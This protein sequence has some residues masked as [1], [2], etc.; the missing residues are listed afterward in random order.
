MDRIQNFLDRTADAPP[1]RDARHFRTWQRISVQVQREVRP[2]A[3]QT[4]FADEA[5]VEGDLDRAFT[6]VVYSSSKPCYGQR[7]M[8]FTYDIGDPAALTAALRLIG[9]SLQARLAKISARFPS[10][11]R[12]KRRFAPIWHMDILNSVKT[13]P[14]TL[15][16][17]LAREATMVNALID[18]GTRRD[19]RTV[20]RFVKSTW[21]AARVMGVDSEA[22]QD[23]VLRT[24]VENLGNARIFEDDHVF[25]TGSPDLRIGGDEDCDHGGPDS[26]GQVADAGIVPDVHACR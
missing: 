25:P 18:L 7:P 12:L 8:E 1:E 20:K 17:L 19:E 11:A 4:F 24:S 26:R 23:L 14:R 3:A 10:H 5:R 6:M 22:L 16:E 21:S 2:F 9:R 15:I 13:K